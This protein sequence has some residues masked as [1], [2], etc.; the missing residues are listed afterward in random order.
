MARCDRKYAVSATFRCDYLAA[1]WT[2]RTNRPGQAKGATFQDIGIGCRNAY[3]SVDGATFRWVS[4]ARPVITAM[5][6]GM[7]AVAV[8]SEQVAARLSSQGQ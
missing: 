7:V 8:V 2:R 5:S 3:A 1:I 4:N 6:S